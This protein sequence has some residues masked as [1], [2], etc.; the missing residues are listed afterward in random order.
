MELKD[1][2]LKVEKVQNEYKKLIESIFSYANNESDNTLEMSIGNIMRR[3][4]EAFSSF[5][6]NDGFEKTLRK[7]E[8][9]ESIP[10]SKRDYYENFMSRL[11]LNSNSHMAENSYS[12]NNATGYFT[13]DE[14]VQTAKSLLLFLL[15]I[16]K[17]HIVSYLSEDKAKI[18]EKW[19]NNETV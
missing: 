2:T 13:H 3:T 4:L 17:P 9:L 15:Y 6:Y 18:I 8:L 1:R 12:L 14:K 7:K 10:K 16:N 5:C 19:E 11:I